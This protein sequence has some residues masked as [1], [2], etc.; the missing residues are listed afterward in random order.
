MIDTRD[1][2]QVLYKYATL[3]R[4]IQSKRYKDTNTNRNRVEAKLKGVGVNPK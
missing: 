4:H 3:F 1:E 2:V